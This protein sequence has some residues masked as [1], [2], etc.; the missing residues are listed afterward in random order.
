MTANLLRESCWLVGLGG[1]GEGWG[2]L[3]EGWVGHTLVLAGSKY[4]L[5]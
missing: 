1:F 5:W 4:V 2:V 3:E